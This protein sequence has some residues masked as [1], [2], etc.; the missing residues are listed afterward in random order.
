MRPLS[1]RIPK[2]ERVKCDSTRWRPVNYCKKAKRVGRGGEKRTGD[3]SGK[4]RKGKE[5]YGN[6]FYGTDRARGPDSAENAAREFNAPRGR[7]AEEGT[8]AGA[9]REARQASINIEMTA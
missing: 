5:N 4:K 2:R 6:I 1:A 8:P 3:S 7:A 9:S